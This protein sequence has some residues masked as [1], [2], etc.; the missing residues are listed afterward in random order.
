MLIA[1]KIIISTK[2][3]RMLFIE[4]TLRTHHLSKFHC[5][6]MGHRFRKRYTYL[7]LERQRNF[8]IEGVFLNVFFL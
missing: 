1:I 6:L 7:N 2:N 3:K 4:T 5:N 8:D